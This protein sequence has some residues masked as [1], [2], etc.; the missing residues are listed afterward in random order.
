MSTTDKLQRIKNRSKLTIQDTKDEDESRT[1]RSVIHTPKATKPSPLTISKPRKKKKKVTIL[2][3]TTPSPGNDHSDSH[4]NME[5]DADSTPTTPICRSTAPSPAPIPSD[6]PDT[7]PTTVADLDSIPQWAHTLSP[8]EKTPHAS[9]F[10]V[11]APAPPI[12]SELAAVLTA[13]TGLHTELINCIDKVNAH[14]DAASGPQTIADY[15]VWNNE[16]LAAW[17]H[18]GYV[19]PTHDADMETLAEA[20]VARE[21]EQLQAQ[22]AFRSLHHRFVNEK[23]MLPLDDNEVYLEKWY[24]VCTD[25]VKSMNWD[26][27]R[28]PLEADDMI[29]NSW[30]R[31]E[32]SLNEE[33]YTLSTHLTFERI[34]GLKPNMS[35]PEGCAQFNTFTT[36]YNEFCATENFPAWEGFPETHD[37]FFKFFLANAPRSTAP[38]L[39]PKPAPP[40]TEPPA[41]TKSVC[42]TSIPP[43]TTLPPPSSS[44]EDFPAL[45]APNKAPFLTHRQ[46]LHSSP[47]PDAAAASKRL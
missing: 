9:S 2:D 43:I 11:P 16:N 7:V 24:Q 37:M 6:A 5:T 45:Q 39:A 23:K 29:L 35:S 4:A 22:R 44:P 30:C 40:T 15:L 41:P 27:Q 36:A 21:A 19:D 32:C 34:T 18:P 31:A 28:I 8:E 47:S 13:L 26:A 1:L 25:L 12:N 14:V 20:N 17:E 38:A 33:E 42:F 10:P 3:L 46:P